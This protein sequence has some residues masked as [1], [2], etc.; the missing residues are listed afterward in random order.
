MRRLFAF[1]AFTASTC[2]FALA[3][4]CTNCGQQ[5]PCAQN[6]PP[7]GAVVMPPPGT[8]AAP[9][10]TPWLPEPSAPPAPP[11]PYPTQ[12]PNPSQSKS[13]DPAQ[14]NRD[15]AWRPGMPAPPNA[16]DV[17]PAAP[18]I[19]GAPNPSNAAAP[20]VRLYPPEV[21]ES[22]GGGSKIQLLPPDARAPEAKPVPKVEES[23]Q[24]K[25]STAKPVGIPHFEMV[26]DNVATGQRPSLDDGLDWL[27]LHGYKVVLFVHEPG[28]SEA[29]ARKQVEKRGMQFVGLAVS[30]PTLSRLVADAFNRIVAEIPSGPLFVY[31]HDGSLTGAMWYLH[32]RLARQLSEDEARSQTRRLGFNA[33]QGDVSRE[34]WQAARR[35]LNDGLEP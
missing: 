1:I 26:S 22:S 27:A 21:E 12:S 25:D 8:T 33:D 35:L 15:L 32:F 29:A 5:R 17:L 6:G 18:G 24:S 20:S 31:D 4:G 9:S 3:L 10:N 14:Y 11:N 30:P 23:Q 28:E 19:Q 13:I 16:Q 34:M 2:I 7:P